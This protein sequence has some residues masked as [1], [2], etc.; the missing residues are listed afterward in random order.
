MIDIYK[1]GETLVAVSEIKASASL[2]RRR[3]ES[4]AVRSILDEIAGKTVSLDHDDNGAP[5]IKGW[6]VSISHSRLLAAVA[7]DAHTKVGIDAEEWR[8]TLERVKARYLS[9]DELGIFTTPNQLLKAWT[10]KEAV[11]KIVGS[12]AVDFA[13]TIAIDASMRS[14]LCLGLVFEIRSLDIGDT[15]ISLAKPLY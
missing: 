13:N 3:L 9:A 6:N 8:P 11:Y 15:H 10:I 12:A 4:Q 7:I 1:I 2:S 5:L 14:A